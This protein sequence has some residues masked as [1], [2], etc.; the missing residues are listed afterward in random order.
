[1][2]HVS[3]YLRIRKVTMK[4]IIKLYLEANIFNDNFRYIFNEKV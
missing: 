3:A 2:R 4:I 1:M